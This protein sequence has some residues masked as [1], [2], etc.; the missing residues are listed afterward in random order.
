MSTDSGFYSADFRWSTKP[1]LK[2][3]GRWPVFGLSRCFFSMLRRDHI[4]FDAVLPHCNIQVVFR[5]FLV[6][7]EYSLTPFLIECCVEFCCPEKGL[8]PHLLFDGASESKPDFLAFVPKN[9]FHPVPWIQ[10]RFP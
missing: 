7:T 2:L 5:P 8:A 1:P 6:G 9:G 3:H 10:R 4:C